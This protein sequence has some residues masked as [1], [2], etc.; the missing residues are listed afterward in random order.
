[1][2]T[3]NDTLGHQAGDELI[4]AVMRLFREFA[5]SDHV[6]RTGGDEFLII[7]EQAD[8][9][10]AEMMVHSMREE[11]YTAGLSVALGW[12]IQRG[13]ITNRDALMTAADRRMYADK[14]QTYRR[15]YTDRIMN[16]YNASGSEIAERDTEEKM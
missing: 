11:M 4:Q 2:K 1:M 13:P 9:K 7:V 6:F 12:V 10:T 5:D 3:T 16:S 15:R 14:G 8:E